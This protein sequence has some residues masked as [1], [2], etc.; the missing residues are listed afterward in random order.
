MNIEKW[1]NRTYPVFEESSTLEDV[2]SV[3][4]LA[5][6]T[7]II[8]VD[9]EGRLSGTAR[10][11]AIDDFDLSRKLSEIVVEPVFYCRDSDFI[12]DAALMLIE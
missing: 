7:N 9:K 8:S 1:I 6:L 4:A 3:K 12:E 2:F 10:L 5:G 11:D